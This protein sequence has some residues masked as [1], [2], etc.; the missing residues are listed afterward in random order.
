M[1]LLPNRVP[2][3]RNL[4]AQGATLGSIEIQAKALKGRDNH[5]FYVALSGLFSFPKS[6][7]GLHP[8]LLD[9][10]P[11]ELRSQFLSNINIDEFSFYAYFVDLYKFT[12]L[13]RNALLITE[14]LLNVI[15]KLAIIGLKN[16]PN[17]G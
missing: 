10:A 17:I 1:N 16:P 5:K 8:G 6:Y 3:G 9:F 12:F 11:L 4:I 15:A 13:S 2:K 7:P 14:T